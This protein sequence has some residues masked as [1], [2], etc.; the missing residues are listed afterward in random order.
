MRVLK[1]N[2]STS[3]HNNKNTKSAGPSFATSAAANDSRA[4]RSHTSSENTLSSSFDTSFS[5]EPAR[6]VHEQLDL[7]V[8]TTGLLIVY[9]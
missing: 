1:E 8:L 2:P 5:S 9:T 3:S 4:S 7:E 6:Y